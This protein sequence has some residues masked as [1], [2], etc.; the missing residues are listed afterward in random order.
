MVSRGPV[1]FHAYGAVAELFGDGHECVLDPEVLIEGPAGT[2]KTRGVLQFID[3]MCWRF[4]GIR[5]LITRKTRASMTESVLVTL[6]DEVWQGVRPTKDRATRATRRAYRYPNGTELVVEGMNNPDRIMSTQY[7]LIA[8]FEATEGEDEDAWE[9]LQTRLR[10]QRIPHPKGWTGDDGRFYDWAYEKGMPRKWETIWDAR[11]DAAFARGGFLQGGE[12]PDGTPCFLAIGLADCNPGAPGHWLNRRPETRQERHDRP[13]MRRLLSRHWHNPTVTEDYLDKLRGLTGARR[14][15]LFLGRWVAESGLVLKEWDAAKHI[16]PRSKV[17]H[18]HT[19]VAGMD[20]GWDHPGNF[21]VWGIADNGDAYRVL[22]VH[23]T[24]KTLNWWADLVEA[25]WEE[26]RFRTIVADPSR[27]ESIEE[28]NRR[29]RKKGG[30][31]AKATCIGADNDIL[32]GLDTLRW[33]LEPAPGEAPRMFWVDDALNKH[34]RDEE[35]AAEKMPCCFED[36]VDSYLWLK[37]R[38][39]KPVE[40]ERPDPNSADD[41]IDVARYVARHLWLV[42]HKPRMR[43]VKYSPGTVGDVARHEQKWNKIKRKTRA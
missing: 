32:T 38:N 17:P 40:K 9:K 15:R 42:E 16:V 37:D 10:N 12:Y 23:Q 13:K 2:G 20:W 39:G 24:G 11:N 36:E 14:E 41:A 35:R 30:R 21:Q 19:Y 7:D 33:A 5:V 43:K 1:Q 22:E 25:E 28:F 3:A 26:Y 34:G 8:Y 6:E 4:P 18:L 31:E 29:L 27:P